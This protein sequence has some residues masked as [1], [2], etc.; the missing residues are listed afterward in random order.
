MKVNNFF[1]IL[2]FSIFPLLSFAN[3][4]TYG[5]SVYYPAKIISINGQSYCTNNDSRFGLFFIIDEKLDVKG[6]LVADKNTNSVEK[7]ISTGSVSNDVFG[8][9][10][11]FSTNSINNSFP[12]FIA[13][14]EPD[15]NKS[16]SVFYLS[17]YINP[18]DFTVES[19]DKGFLYYFIRSTQTNYNQVYCA[20]E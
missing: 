10:R 6:L 3:T 2:F 7:Y 13:L 18:T 15:N 17:R 20:K 4:D 14:G 19:I 1:I 9:A 12:K 11:L 5:M 8:K 16:N